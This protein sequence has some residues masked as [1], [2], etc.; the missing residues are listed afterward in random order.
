MWGDLQA[1]SV[2]ASCLEF[3]LNDCKVI[4]KVLSTPFREQVKYLLVFPAADG[5]QGP[6]ALCLVRALRVYVS[7][8]VRG[9][10]LSAGR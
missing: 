4:Y 5:E 7:G 8:I 9:E 2:S 6:D 1:P 10:D 3:E